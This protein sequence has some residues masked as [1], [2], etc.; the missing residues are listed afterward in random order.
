MIPIDFSEITLRLKQE[1]GKVLVFD[2]VRKKWLVLTPE[3]QVRQYLLMH[4]TGVMQ[5][6]QNLIAVEKKIMV[7]AM[8]K[9]FDIVV[10]D[11]R[12]HNPWMLI[13]CKAPDIPITQAALMQLLNYQR[14]IQ[15]GYWMLSNGHQHFCADARN[16]TAISWLPAL[17]AYD[18]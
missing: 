3:E 7:G 10:Y 8:A 16:I 17:P 12:T 1:D 2:P 11:R 6:P 15:C 14:T 4:L 9:R 18:L 5:Y 13:E